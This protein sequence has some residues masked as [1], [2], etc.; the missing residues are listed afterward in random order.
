MRPPFARFFCNHL[1]VLLLCVTAP[2]F[3]QPADGPRIQ[4]Q[5][6]KVSGNTLLTQ[7]QI[8]AVLERYK[9]ERSIDELKR[10]AA[11]LQA[12]Y[13]EAGYGAVVA[14]VPEQ[15][16]QGNEV[17]IT[18]VEGRIA[19]VTVDGEQQFSEANIRASLPSLIEGR[20][21]LVREIDSQIQLAN[22]NPAKHIDVLL[23]PG[24]KLGEVDARIQVVEEKTSRYTIG[25]DNTGNANTGRLRANFGYQNAALFDRD[26]VLALQLQV[27]PEKL[28]SVT[29][30]S[31]NYRIPLYAQ[32]MAIDA[33]AA[34]SDVDGGT[35]ATAAGPLQFS[36]KGQIAGVRLTKY[37]P[38]FGEIDHRLIVGL[39]NRDYINNCNIVGLPAGACGNAGESV[40]VQP[41]A[42]EYVIQKGGENR[43]GASIGLLHNLHLGGRDGDSAQFEKVRPG[44]E[45]RYTVL[46]VGLFAALALPEEWQVQ[47]R[48]VGQTTSDKLVPGEQFGIGGASSVRGY[49]EREIT[50]DSGAS[51][52]LELISPDLAK[53]MGSQG[54][55]RLLAF[56]D[57]GW[58]RNHVNSTQRLE[59]RLGDSECRIGSVGVGLRYG[60]GPLQA[61]LDIA[62]ALAAGNRTG[63]HDAR[64]HFS[65]S[66]SF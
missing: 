24:D 21:P 48:L 6:F 51:G 40:S 62:Y 10:A 66:Y 64:A 46:R 39:D 49:E 15:A 63:R 8:D 50:G 37:L 36:G 1:S 26:H 57:A 33:Y 11:A 38:R 23:Q 60:S 55:L 29:V 5:S 12:L 52:A 56:L 20:T 2:A 28:D 53:T 65:V 34:Y 16:P 3:A 27:A 61:R 13:R 42:V 14:F 17:A 30:V 31:A 7:A 43:Y 47:M 18:V 58:V 41:L 22:E 9:G 44:A 54:S 35:N 25:L 19:N 4:V 59:C 45:P 32:G